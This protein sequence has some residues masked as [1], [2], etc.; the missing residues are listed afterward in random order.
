MGPARQQHWGELARSF[1]IEVPEVASEEVPE[2]AS[3]EVPEV[4]GEEVP[5]VASEAKP[6]V[7]KEEEPKVT[8]KKDDIVESRRKASWSNKRSDRPRSDEPPSDPFEEAPQRENFLEEV[9]LGDDRFSSIDDEASEPDAEAGTADEAEPRSGRRRRRGRQRRRRETRE[10]QEPAKTNGAR[11]NSNRGR[12]SRWSRHLPT[13]ANETKKKRNPLRNRQRNRDDD[14]D[15][16]A[17]SVAPPNLT[18]VRRKTVTVDRADRRSVRLWRTKAP[19]GERVPRES[20]EFTDSADDDRDTARTLD[21]SD[22]MGDE[23]PGER[24]PRRSIPSWSEAI[25]EIVN[26][27][28]AGRQKSPRRPRGGRGRRPQSRDR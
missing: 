3:E 15:G 1:G 14:G 8:E 12:S 10:P 11:K 17:A 20:A 5:E 2:V 19:A 18:P 25:Q 9:D 27:N 22:E 23:R 7:A 26:R 16:E 4:A 28:I 21:E 24:R 13:S 6:K